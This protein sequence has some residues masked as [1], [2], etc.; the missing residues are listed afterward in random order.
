MQDDVSLDGPDGE[1]R[2]FLVETSA[3]GSRLDAWLHQ[4]IPEC[5]RGTISRWIQD[6]AILVD[7][8]QAKPNLKPKAGQRIEVTS[9]A[10]RP[11]ELKPEPMALDVLYEDEHL[12]VINKP[13]GLVVHPAAGHEEGTL[14]HGL[15]HHCS[16]QLS[17]IGGVARPGI[18]HRLDQDTSG[19]MIVAKNDVAHQSLAKQFADRSVYKA[20][21]AV[22][23]GRVDP[24]KG[25]IDAPI[26]RHHSQRKIMAVVEGGRRAVTDYEVIQHFSDRATYLKAI[27]HTGRTHQIRVHFKHLGHPL[28]GDGTYGT[29]A[30][31]KLAKAIG[32]QPPRQL[33][34]A[35]KLSFEHPVTHLELAL[36]AAIP[37]DFQEALERMAASSHTNMLTPE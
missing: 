16:G 10:A 33:L 23:C 20:Y 11:L 18:V 30:A 5:S 3:L 13:P 32:Y 34:H 17:G 7:G 31:S 35:W 9:P 4:R 8:R 24:V 1:S 37:N 15:L 29:K 27:L 6:G 26:A 28:F 12:I 2:V 25:T 22:V 36:T 14:V 21:L 19:C